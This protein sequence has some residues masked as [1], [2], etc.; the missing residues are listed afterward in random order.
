MDILEKILK[1]LTARE[2]VMLSL[3][4]K[5]LNLVV[6]TYI[7]HQVERMALRSQFEEFCERNRDCLLPKEVVLKD[8]LNQNT[9]PNLLLFSTGNHFIGEKRFFIKKGLIYCKIVRIAQKVQNTV[10]QRVKTQV[11]F[12][13][14][15][16]FVIL[17]QGSVNGYGIEK[18]EGAIAIDLN[19]VNSWSLVVTTLFDRSNFEP[20]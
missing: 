19:Q 4:S 9:R 18:Y 14:S 15:Y 12:L 2:L 13:F 5:A 17:T 8:R 10:P 6:R 11:P 1:F 16:Y 20:P 7:D 3:T